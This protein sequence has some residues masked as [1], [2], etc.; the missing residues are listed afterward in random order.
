MHSQEEYANG[1]V[2]VKKHECRSNLYQ[3]W[4]R[5]FM[6]IN[7]YNLQLYSNVFQFIHNNRTK[8]REQ[9]FM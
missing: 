9:R 3:I 6:G 2:H 7:K 5:K 1:N 8:E 4:I